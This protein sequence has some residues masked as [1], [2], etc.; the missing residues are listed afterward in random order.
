MAE[1]GTGGLSPKVKAVAVGIG[2]IALVSIALVGMAFEGV[3]EGEVKVVKDRGAVTGEVLD[4]GWHVVT[5]LVE[6]TVSVPTRPQ[7]YTMS[8][9][10]WDSSS[11]KS[12]SIHIISR[13]GQEIHVDVT[14][15]YRIDAENAPTFHS[16]YRDIPTVE[17]RLIRPT[18]RSVVRDEAS[19]MSAREVIT[20]D[21]R[22]ALAE[23][24]AGALREDFEGSGVSLEAVQV[25][26]MHLNPQFKDELEQIEIEEARAEQKKI[27]AEADREAFEIRAEALRENPELLIELYIEALDESDTIY[28]PV[29]EGGLPTYLDVEE[30][31]RRADNGTTTR[32]G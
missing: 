28:V 19:D 8:G 29:G 24:A 18:V 32:G 13:D 3:D 9:S 16:E 22:E 27:E 6:S 31:E 30:F 23:V 1:Y 21:G 11:E 5:P 25:R 17:E 2:L 10:E 20:K 4:P 14:V 15:R 12:D 7:T 26:N